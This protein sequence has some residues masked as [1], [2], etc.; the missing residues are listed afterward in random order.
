MS[1]LS[2]LIQKYYNS[3]IAVYGLGTETERVLTEIDDIIQIVGLLDGYRESGELYG[4][5][6][7]SLEEAVAYQVKLIL[8]VARPG[9]CKAIARRIGKICREHQIDLF[10][11]RGKNLNDV[12]KTTYD[13]KEVEG[14]TKSKLKN[15]ISQVDIVSIDLF[16][17]LIMRQTLFPTDI[18]EMMDIILKEQDI[19]IENFCE[20]RLASEKYLSKSKAPSLIDIYAYM[21][22]TCFVPTVTPEKLAELEWQTDYELVVPR[23]ELC[24][25]MSEVRKQGKEIYVVSDTYYTKKQLGLILKKCN[26]TFYTDIFASCE[27]GTGKTQHLFEKLQS[28]IAGKKCIHIGDDITTDIESAQRAG[29]KSCQIYSGIEL[30]ETVGY[31]GLW[32]NTESLAN[33]IKV[34]MFVSRLFNSPFWF[35]TKEKKISISN[36]YDIGWLFFAP[37]ITDFVIWFAKQVRKYHLQNIWFCSRDGYLIKK[38]YDE[39]VG[40]TSST[41]FLTSRSATIRAGMENEEDIRYVEEMVFG[42]TLSEQLEERFGIYV[43]EEGNN[44]C[45]S[46]YMGTILDQAAKERAGYQS[47]IKGLKLKEGDIAFFDFVAK[48]TSQMYIGRL[49]ENHLTGLY[50]LQLDEEY[51]REKGLDIVSFYQREEKTESAIFENYYILETVLTAPMP[52]VKGFSEDGKP[53]Y[54]EETRLE[55]DI[56][57]FLEAQKGI[58][59]YFETYLRICQKPD[60]IDKKLDEKFLEM[61]HNVLILDQNFLS[62]TVEDPFFNRMTDMTD[63]V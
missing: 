30:F 36:V 22:R 25:F 51:M 53:Y 49:V 31:L 58:R 10:D 20:K 2:Q 55:K 17:T 12:K 5:P 35:E 7:I 21:L 60:G 16:D 8:V 42:G 23:Q 26:I 19:I 63:L 48:G 47:Y 46:D 56:Q 45:L 57:C 3:K 50:F 38:L 59:D 52:S 43:K 14:I 39:L 62:L 37:M 29:M 1:D 15:L 18:Y 27:Y 11:I 41:Y 40:N 28:R 54:A 13:F 4:K 9:S 61:I 44:R 6:I 33:R 24:D 32:E 34:G